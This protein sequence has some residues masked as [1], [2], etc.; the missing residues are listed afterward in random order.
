VSESLRSVRD[1]HGLA[2]IVR[3]LL[4]AQAVVAVAAIASAL[5]HGPGFDNETG[6]PLYLLVA[7][8]QMLVYIV[9][10]VLV[11]RW[12]YLAIK[13]DP[14]KYEY[15]DQALTPVAD[16]YTETLEMFNNAGAQAFVSQTK[17]LD[18]IAH[19]GEYAPSLTP[20][21]DDEV[22]GVAPGQVP[23]SS[24]KRAVVR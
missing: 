18:K 20:S 11:L 15:M 23:A 14:K 19:G 13:R 8:V 4:A 17:R 9:A 7:M 3:A 5:A 22:S 10:G 24:D 12:I 2:R 6:S 21:A 16:D 1:L